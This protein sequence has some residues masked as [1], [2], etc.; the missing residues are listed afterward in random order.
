MKTI[1]RLFIAVLVSVSAS[2]C[3]AWLE[4][5][6][7]NDI[8]LEDYWKSEK[9][10]RLALNQCYSQLRGQVNTLFLWGD[11]RGDF[12]VDGASN[13]GDYLDYE[14]VLR[15]E[16]L[17]NNS[18]S[19]WGGIYKVINYANNVIKY[20]PGVRSSDLTLGKKELN[21]YLSEAY[22]LRSLSYFYLVRTFKDVPLQLEPTDTDD[23]N[24]VL[25]KS[26]EEE[27]LAQIVTDLE[28]A[29]RY[30]PR[31][32]ADPDLNRGFAT[33]AAVQALLA[34]VY[35]W[36]E[37]YD[38]CIEKCDK[39]INRS[40]YVLVE[41]WRDIF[42]EGNTIESIFELP[43]DVARGEKSP[44]KNVFI[45]DGAEVLSASTEVGE[46]F[47]DRDIRKINTLILRE[48]ED[49]YTIVKPLLVSNV[50]DANWI[51]YRYAEVLL[52]KAE[53]LVQKDQYFE[54]QLIL[55]EIRERAELDVRVI[56]SNREV[57]E[58]IILEERGMELAFEGK[59]WFDLLRMAK[60]NNYQRKEKLIDLMTKGVDPGSVPKW[61]SL[62]TDP[63]SHYMPIHRDELLSNPNLTQ[64]PYY[65]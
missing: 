61:R 58:D 60:R 27:V 18:L 43:Y 6:P 57:A 3:G 65:D 1:F 17:D 7:Q 37:D 48:G 63:M 44:L 29:E 50:E 47:T 28:W 35:L 24:V 5:E 25:P 2:S 12:V 45:K 55:E 49:N 53:A 54:A 15:L 22:F 26:T 59:R 41:F 56:P 34:D 40:D 32:Y 20:A 64:N 16:I 36:M 46:L 39:I 23:V 13:H 30:I 21:A 11:L 42:A 4:V 51:V 31:R 62:L 8:T 52:M 33:Q 14:R 19:K 10:I 38:K 9:D